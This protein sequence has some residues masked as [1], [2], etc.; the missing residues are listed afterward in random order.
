MSDASM[1]GMIRFLLARL[2]DEDSALKREARSRRFRPETAPTG[3]SGLGSPARRRA[4]NESKRLVVGHAQH[5]LLLRDLP[6]EQPVR[7][8]A[9]RM[10]RAMAA[11]YDNHVSYRPEWSL[12][13]PDAQRS[14][15]TSE[16]G[17]AQHRSTSSLAGASSG[18]AV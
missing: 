11:V 17:R 3:S 10:L 13:R 18:G 1:T 12:T 8:V 7:E 14:S 5:L 15:T 9:A 6:V 16:A 4:D 2:D